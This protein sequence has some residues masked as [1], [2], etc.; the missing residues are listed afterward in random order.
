MQDPIIQ[1][2][3]LTWNC[4]DIE[5]SYEPERHVMPDLR[6][7]HLEVRSVAPSRAPLP[8]TETGYRSHFCDPDDIE[9]R[10]GPLAF[11]EAWLEAEACS[12][13]W[14]AADMARRQLELF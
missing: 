11:V 12:P 1:T 6:V 8:I 3:H 2:F 7:A 4:I 9:R 5:I 10:G 14:R 13:T